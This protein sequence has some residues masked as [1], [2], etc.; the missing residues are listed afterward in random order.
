MVSV[1][2]TLSIDTHQPAPPWV[3]DPCLN[4]YL[5]AWG[6]VSIHPEARL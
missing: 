2:T 3:P 1:A 5:I 6:P 4:A